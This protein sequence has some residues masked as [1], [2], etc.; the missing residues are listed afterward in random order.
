MKWSLVMQH[1]SPLA[2]LPQQPA[3]RRRDIRGAM[4]IEVLVA[5]LIF[6]PQGLLGRPAVAKV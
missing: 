3:M 5:I 2:P 4:L 1:R 6:R